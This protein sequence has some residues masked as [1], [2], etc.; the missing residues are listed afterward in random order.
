MA[1]LWPKL[2]FPGENEHLLFLMVEI[3]ENPAISR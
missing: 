3:R 2:F 1:V